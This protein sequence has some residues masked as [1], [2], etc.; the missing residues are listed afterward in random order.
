VI[1]NLWKNKKKDI[2]LVHGAGS[3]GHA[4]VIEK[5]LHEVIDANKFKDVFEVQN[6]CAKLCGFVVEALRK[7]G[8]N[9]QRVAPNKIIRSEKARIV[10]IDRQAITSLLDREITPVLHGDMVLDLEWNYSVVSG[11]QIISKLTNLAEFSVLATDVDGI[12]VDGKII[13]KID[14]KN[15]EQIKKHLRQ[16]SSPDV[17]GGML[18]KVSELKDAGG[19]YFI[20]N[21]K[22]PQRI[23]AIF[24]NK[25]TI[26]T[27]LEFDKM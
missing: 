16:S 20:V 15:F 12:I 10:D 6:Q 8:V 1:G 25:K 14:R 7:N 5:G 27:E 22:Y 11:D 21:A 4:L 2:V 17:T 13:E 24:D 3:F 19:K 9:S 23:L 26:C 18:G